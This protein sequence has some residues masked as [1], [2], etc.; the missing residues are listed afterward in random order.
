MSVSLLTP[1]FAISNNARF[2]LDR[3]AP[4]ES[5]HQVPDVVARKGPRALNGPTSLWSEVHVGFRHRT[6]SGKASCIGVLR[7]NAPQL[8]KS[9]AFD[10]GSYIV[11]FAKS[12][13]PT[14]GRSS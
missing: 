6:I 11:G 5:S 4:E 3:I 2:G 8:Q 7:K 1:E 9:Q 10:P 14:R 12:V 13:Q